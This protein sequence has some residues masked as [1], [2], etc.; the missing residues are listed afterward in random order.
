MHFLNLP[1]QCLVALVA[2]GA[3]AKSALKGPATFGE[4]VDDVQSPQLLRAPDDLRLLSDDAFSV[5]SHVAFP[6]HSV[7]IKKSDFCDG[8]VAYVTSPW[9]SRCTD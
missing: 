6:R 1:Q 9:T 3:A 8:T 4:H 2:V 5:L 7:R